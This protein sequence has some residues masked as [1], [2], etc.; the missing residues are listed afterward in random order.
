[1]GDIKLTF[2][3]SRVQAHSRSTPR[4]SVIDVRAYQAHRMPARPAPGT[5]HTRAALDAMDW[6]QQRK[7]KVLPCAQGRKSNR[8]ACGCEPCS[9]WRGIQRAR[10][11]ETRSSFRKA[12]DRIDG[13]LKKYWQKTSNIFK[14]ESTPFAVPLADD[15]AS[16]R[17]NGPQDDIVQGH[18]Q[19][20]WAAE[21]HAAAP[22]V[23]EEAPAEVEQITKARQIQKAL[24]A[25]IEA[26]DQQLAHPLDNGVRG[27]LLAKHLERLVMADRLTERLEEG[28]RAAK[29]AQQIRTHSR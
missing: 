28:E 14:A 7:A 27:E 1:M 2:G 17:D 13:F 8:S 24:Q 15:L 20:P 5:V 10:M 19:L 6:A 12:V 21:D 16:A 25:E 4:G 18:E 26:L 3:K 9:V 11:K 22:A 29:V 23:E